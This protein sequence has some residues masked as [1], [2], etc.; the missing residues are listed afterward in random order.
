MKKIVAVVVI[1]MVL[2]F[3][4]PLGA[5]TTKYWQLDSPEK[6]LQGKF[7]GTGINSQ[8]KV[9][10][11]F[12]ASKITFPARVIWGA[13]TNSRTI[14]VGSSSPA[15][16]FL[17]ED[18][19]DTTPEKLV[20]KQ[21]VGFTAFAVADEKL[22][23]GLS[24]TGK[25]YSYDETSD[26]IEVVA[27]LGD[28]L[29]L[30]M[31]SA[32]NKD[33]VYIGTGNNGAIYY[34][35]SGGRIRT[36][37]RLREQ[38]VMSLCQFGDYLYAGDAHGTLYRVKIDG[39]KKVEPVY[40]FPRAEIRALDADTQ[41]LYLG[42]NKLASDGQKK[43]NKEASKKIAA[44]IK[45]KIQRKM[46]QSPV[47]KQAGSGSS[48]KASDTQPGGLPVPQKSK[49]HPPRTDSNQLK[50]RLKKA[51]RQGQQQKVDKLLSGRAGAAVVK[52]RPPA[53]M[54]VLISNNQISVFDI[55][56]EGGDV[57][58]AT[59]GE[60]RVYRINKDGSKTVYF[61]TDQ[62]QVTELIPGG[63][64]NIRFLTTAN[65]GVLFKK[66]PFDEIPITYRSPVLDAQLLSQWGQFKATASGRIKLRTRS[67]LTEKP[68]TFWNTWSSWNNNSSFAIRS[69]PARF[70]QFEVQFMN[71]SAELETTEIARRASNQRPRIAEFKVSPD[72]QRQLLFNSGSQNS[73]SNHGSSGRSHSLSSLL[74]A[75]RQKQ[76]SPGRELGWKAMDPD[77]DRLEA[78]LYYRLLDMENWVKLAGADK[79]GQQSNYKWQPDNFSDGRYKFKL[80]VTDRPLNPPA[81]SYQTE[82]IVGPVLVDNSQ[83]EIK[84]FE[85]EQREISFAA[86]D[87]TSR[88]FFVRFRCPGHD[89]RQL[90]PEDG[91]SDELSETYEFKLP[92][93]YEQAE[94]V[95]F[96]VIDGAGNQRLVKFPIK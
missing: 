40:Q 69:E 10:P 18:Y 81:R 35:D 47:S 2:A 58:V 7:N 96:L 1:M 59:G 32:R 37:A 80:V 70:F 19:S 23:A 29:V 90:R 86:V 6:F 3:A 52:F 79:I 38:A 53:G 77:G 16:L 76:N 75:S 60:G 71:P 31:L 36:I 46:R 14:L 87:Q 41:S 73:G 20:Q 92:A 49:I 82:R 78:R 45:Q 51:I 93:E 64:R 8:G 33:G 9:L 44:Q 83:P 42:I 88:I 39:S 21:D 74:Q 89:W 94:L 27:D 72:P 4:L 61:S 55:S 43:Q 56:V 54:N 13:A 12:S 17:L 84:G 67:G 68:D 11:T 63:P 91:V 25:I 26:T 34:L 66:Q 57:F 95:E 50:E 62:R 30:S 15:A 85:A 28:S 24:S 5:A 65:G 22:Y 48:V